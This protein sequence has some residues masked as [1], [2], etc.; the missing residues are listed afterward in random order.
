MIKR[1]FRAENSVV[2]PTVPLSGLLDHG[3]HSH[4]RPGSLNASA[5]AE[6]SAGAAAV[7]AAIKSVVA[8]EHI[9]RSLNDAT[10]ILNDNAAIEHHKVLRFQD[11]SGCAFDL[12]PQL[13]P[14]VKL[15]LDGNSKCNF[16]IRCKILS[17]HV[18]V[19]HCSNVKLDVSNILETIQ[20][21]LSDNI[22]VTC[23][24]DCCHKVYH[25]GS[26]NL[27]ICNSSACVLLDDFDISASDDP[28]QQF[29]TEFVPVDQQSPIGFETTRPSDN[30]NPSLMLAL[31]TTR[32][33][34]EQ[35]PSLKRART[36]PP[37]QS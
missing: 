6:A 12:G 10:L 31:E 14:L 17:S 19:T 3:N 9:I 35:S 13:G 24:V 23:D 4:G 30:Q 5:P 7:T 11:N 37:S 25:A 2:V 20:V 22:I 16:V 8:Q 27:K 18:E 32:P 36:E 29:V 15:Y 33:S 34:D 21:D 28:A 1:R 26:T